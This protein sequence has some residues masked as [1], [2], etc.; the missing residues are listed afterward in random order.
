MARATTAKTPP[1]PAHELVDVDPRVL[2]IGANARLDPRVD[3][4]FVASIKER[5]VLQP[6]LAHRNDGDLV[7]IAGQ[8]R[9]L[10]AIQA[11]R[12]TVP[13]IVVPEPTDADRLVDQVVENVHRDGLTTAERVAAAEQLALLGVTPAQIAKRTAL[14]RPDV[15]QALAVAKSTTAAAA[16]KEH[17]LTLD[18]AAALVEFED[19]DAAVTDLLSAIDRGRGLDHEVQRLR[20]ERAQAAMV[21]AAAAELAAAGV[22]VL[23]R[24]SAGAHRLDYL[25]HDGNDLTPEAHASCPGHAAWVDVDWVYDDEEPEDED[26]AAPDECVAVPVYACT[27]AVAQGHTYRSGAPLRT[28]TGA[29]GSVG[30]SEADREQEREQRR[31]VIANNKAWRSAQ[32]VRRAWLAKFAARKTAPKTAGALIA[33]SLAWCDHH[34]TGALQDGH[35]YG[36]ELLGLDRGDYGSRGIRVD[37][38]L[39]SAG[40]ARAL[41]VALILV[42]AAYEERLFDQA[43]RGGSPGAARYLEYLAGEGYQLSDIEQLACKHGGAD[44]DT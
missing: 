38:H 44:G 8:R 11:G 9:T 41:H 13:V 29:A 39:T 20:D 2:V 15:D 17:S 24:Y 25:A 36:H 28:T 27:D 37:Q 42:L 14:P 32:T 22:T 40:D 7:V 19:D 35:T 43:W 30:K 26:D 18:Q 4:A 3:K 31:T 33:S 10:A 1:A 23:D 16:L 34:L 6:I 12:D 21:A 5:G